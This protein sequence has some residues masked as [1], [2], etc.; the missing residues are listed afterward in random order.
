MR[1]G[2]LLARMGSAAALFVAVAAPTATAA[3]PRIA[4]VYAG[5]ETTGPFEIR[6]AVDP[7]SVDLTV[8]APGTSGEPLR[9]DTRLDGYDVVFVDGGTPGLAEHAAQLAAAAAATRVVVVTPTSGIAGNVDLATHPAIEQYW[10]NPSQDNYRHLVRYLV[11]RVLGRS[12]AAP[13]A[14]PVVYPAMGFYHPR[15]PRLFESLD[16]LAEWARSD[17]ASRGAKPAGDRCT[18]GLAFTMTSYVQKNLAH[19][20]ALVAAVERRGHRAIAL[21]YRG[22]PDPTRLVQDGKAAV[23]VLIQ[24]GSVFAIRDRQVF[25]DRLAALDVPVVS[26][27]HHHSQDEAQYAASPT[28]LLPTL[29]S[30]VVEAEQEARFEPMAISG[31]GAPRGDSTFVAAID[32]AIEWR[33]DRALGWATLRHTPNARKRLLF[34]YWSQGGG[35]ANV[36]GDPDDF[37]DVPATIARLLGDMRAR[38]YDVGPGAL[39]D[40]DTIA[41]RMALEGSN[42]GTWAPGELATRVA[43]GDVRLVPEAE[44][45]T[46]FDAL[47]AERRREIVDMW[48]PPPGKVGVYTDAAGHRSLV[49]PGLVYGNVVFAPNPDWGYLQ[50]AKAL[51]ST[52]ALPPHHQ[53]VAFFLWMQKTW[54]ADAWVSFFSNISLQGGKPVGPLPDDHIAQLLGAVPHIHPERLGANGGLKTTRKALGRTTS[55]YSLVRPSAVGAQYA[56]LRAML[57]RYASLEDD[58]LRPDLERLVRAE[59]ERSGFGRLVGDPVHVPIAELVAAVQQEIDRLDRLFVPSGSKVLGAAAEGDVRI[60]MVTAMLGRDLTVRLPGS[61]TARASLARVLVQDVVGRGVAPA[62]AVRRRLGSG[63]DDVTATLATATAHAANLA[64]AP[65]EVEA[66]FAALDGRWIAP[67]SMDDPLRRPDALPP[68]RSVYN[69]DSAEVPTIEAEAV[70]V[71]QAEA[72]IA[73]HRQQ[74]AGAWPTSMAFAIFSGE[75]AKN[76]GITEA[77]ILHLLGTRAARDARGIVTGVTLIP[78]EELGRPRV[79]ILLT[80]SGTYRDHYPDVMALIAKATRLAATSPEDDNPVRKAMTDAERQLREQG[81]PAERATVLAQARVFAPAPGAYSP[82][83]QFLAKSGDQR[84]DERKMAE[85]YTSRLSHAYGAGLYG[86]P[87]RPAFER[88]LA[89]V[90]GAT[91]ARSD[92]VN[93]MLDNP[94]PAGFLGGLNLAAKAVTGRNIDLYVSNLRDDRKPTLESAATEIQRELRT[95]YFNTSWLKEMQGHGYEGAR[96]FM[97]L[98]DHLDLWNTTA[99]QTV[100]SEDWREIKRVYVDDEHGLDMDRFFDRYNPHA[101]QI[102]LGNLLG[103]ATRGH[104]Q[105]TAAERTEISARLARSAATHGVACE[106]SLCRNPALTRLITDTLSTT[107]EGRSLAARYTAAIAAATTVAPLPE[108]TATRVGDRP[109]SA[110]VAN[111]VGRAVPGPG[112]RAASAASAVSRPSSAG[113]GQPLVTGRVLETVSQPAGHPTST[114]SANAWWLLLGLASVACVLAGWVREARAHP[115]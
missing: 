10:A 41:R 114:S 2:H 82:S 95:R 106:A 30:A 57:Q 107:A 81:T 7:A 70:G 21:A 4:I 84:G 86:E 33:V 83:I 38:G 20:D 89:R 23:D 17:V 36:G 77:Q 5:G 112:R 16:A 88:Q 102:L 26:A 104:W 76:R 80:T 32:P 115:A 6:R 92:V 9:P 65:R 12:A 68:G 69:F 111:R 87:A 62:E 67:G 53:Y 52:G 35:K 99:S 25:L 113:A 71:R 94:M 1:T 43:R 18:V 46:W 100:S 85:L 28:G 39:P 63:H 40:R 74:H 91:F 109:A 8:F 27:F 51:M 72:L 24:V 29:G 55:W 61:D 49:V 50:D 47:P 93:G 3:V 54:R 110:A 13:P 56:A 11:A 45:Q 37:L 15:A 64:S 48:G 96:T 103:A 73:A 42:V 97:Y 14:P 79:D 98:T 60:D 31:R 105:A 78:R 101:Q 90:D 66:L 59:V 34:T 22:A 75:I 19:V 108:M 44:Y 58:A